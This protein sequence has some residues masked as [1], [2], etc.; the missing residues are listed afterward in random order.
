[1]L[2]NEHM[3]KAAGV[4]RPVTVVQLKPHLV[5]HALEPLRRRIKETCKAVTA[6]ATA[7]NTGSV[8]AG[9]MHLRCM[10]LHL[11]CCRYAIMLAV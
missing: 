1:V 5:Q 8:H 10:V 6:A 11:R 4:A 7:A 3:L 9:P 2:A